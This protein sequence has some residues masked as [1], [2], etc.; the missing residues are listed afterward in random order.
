MEYFVREFLGMFLNIVRKYMIIRG[1][2]S[3][4][5]LSTMSGIPESTLSRL[6]NEKTKELDERVIANL[7]AR[8]EIPIYEIADF[9]REESVEKFRLE[10]KKYRPDYQEESGNFTPA[11]GME[12]QKGASNFE[13][14]LLSSALGQKAAKPKGQNNENNDQEQNKSTSANLTLREKLERLSPRQK[15]YIT[16]FLEL[17]MEGRDLIVDLGS[18][19]FRYFRQRGLE[20]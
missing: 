15:A 14:G 20:F 12:R 19:L 9:I 1:N 7:C 11:P 5:E 18:S 13:E 6:L 16:D 2:L 3:Q 8:L 4:K 10:V 17:D